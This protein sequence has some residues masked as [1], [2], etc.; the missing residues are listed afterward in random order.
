MPP[1][2]N[3]DAR[4]ADIFR[5]WVAGRTQKAIAADRGI[6]QPSVSEAIARH[7]ARLGPDDLED[8]RRDDLARLEALIAA[9][10]DKATETTSPESSLAAIV[11]MLRHRAKVLGYAAPARIDATVAAIT[12]EPPERLEVTYARMM[13]EGNGG[14]HA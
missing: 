12:S 9:H 10:W 14:A 11:A 13:A 3:Q 8:A 6:S 7:R 1:V 5:A 2:A 4:D